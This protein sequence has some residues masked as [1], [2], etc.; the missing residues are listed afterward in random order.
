MIASKWQRGLLV[1]LLFTGC[2]PMETPK[3]TPSA[4]LTSLVADVADDE[5]KL[6]QDLQSKIKQELA[7][8]CGTPREPNVFGD[9][10][11]DLARLRR[12]AEI[13]S[14]RCVQCHGVNGDGQGAVAKYLNPKPRDYTKGIFK[15]TS[16][17]YGSK[18]RRS[19]LL[20]VL[21]RGVA[22]T[23]MPSFDDLSNDQLE[24]LVDYVI[25]LAERGELEKEL[26]LLA[27]DEESLDPEL[28]EESVGTVHGRWEDAQSQLVMP[29]T[30]MPQNTAETIAKGRDLFLQ[31]ACNKCHGVDGRG[32]SVGNVE[33]GK[34]AWGNDGTAADL[35]SGMFRGG[36]R[37]ID[38]YRRIHSGINGTPMPSFAQVFA[39]EPDNIWYLV[40]FI[41]DTGER[42]RRDQPPVEEQAPSESPTAP[43]A[44]EPGREPESQPAAKAAALIQQPGSEHLFA[45]F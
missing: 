29:Q 7:T 25:F 22:G 16:T 24:A 38:I 42:R 35:T 26:V 30:P 44:T 45:N 5:R 19:D 10:K 27:Q 2:R 14:Q 9:S 39:S 18:P 4:E 13:F 40:H 23:S 32:G 11:A 1:A 31:Q 34:D 33:I 8:H 3:F 37:P 41:R 15:F 43:S 6:W 20:L 12:G 28:V 36:G 17:P 21:R